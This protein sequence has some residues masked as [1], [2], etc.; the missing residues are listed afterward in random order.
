VPNVIL[1]ALIVYFVFVYINE[2]TKFGRYLFAIGGDED[3]AARMGINVNKYRI[4]AFALSGL[5]TGFATLFLS[6][7]LGVVSGRLG[8]TYLFNALIAVVIGGTPLSGGIGGVKKTFIGV[9]IITILEQK[10][11]YRCFDNYNLREWDESHWYRYTC[12]VY[13]KNCGPYFCSVCKLNSCAFENRFYEV[14]GKG[15][16]TRGKREDNYIT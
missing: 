12:A 3:V 16:R 8:P 13:N 7:K 9:L 11:I 6:S 14:N 1:W 4:I 5:L 15:V 2:K 10:N